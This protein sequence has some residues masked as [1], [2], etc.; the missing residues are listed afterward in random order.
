LAELFSEEIPEIWDTARRNWHWPQLP[1]PKAGKVGSNGEFPFQN[2][3][4]MLTRDELRHGSLYLESLFE[5]LIVHYIFCPRSM[6]TAGALALSAV[7]GLKDPALA[8]TM[9]NIFTDIVVDSFRLE[10]SCE[11]EEKVV[12]AWS[13]I[14]EQELGARDR[15]VLGFLSKYWGVSLLDCDLPEVDLLL[16]A[17]SPGVR[18]R[19]LWPRQC[20]Q[21]AR[22]LE[23]LG[24]GRLGKGPIR[25]VEI[26]NGSADSVPMTS[27]AS[28]IEPEVY[29]ST[30]LALGIKGDLKR[31]YRD[32]SCEIEIRSLGR[33][34]ESQYPAGTTRWRITDPPSEIDIPYSLSLSPRLIPGI[35][36]YKRE[37]EI[38]Q[39]AEM[40]DKVPDLLAVL[41]SSKSMEGHRLGT[42]THKAT[43][44]A[45]KACQFAHS[46]GAEVAAINFGDRFVCQGWTRD[47]GAVEDVLVEYHCTRTH[48]PGKA[49]SEL[50]REREGCLIL[51]ITDTH[52]Q[53]L[54]TEWESLRK[55][56]KAG[57]FVLICIDQERKDKQVDEALSS[58][59]STYYVDEVEDLVGLVV[60]VTE[61]AYSR[62]QENEIR[63]LQ[64]ARREP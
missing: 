21:T 60:D 38:C 27:L 10:R 7:R 19:S 44:A 14:A 59:G 12:L 52:I 32:Q 25:S 49:I 64:A 29:E 1:R 58:L 17:F 61:R 42:K 43:L 63:E 9:V 3:D 39:M 24:P 54:H 34:R 62:S 4:L 22:I 51:C 23:G 40:G 13:L 16:Q 56:S 33:K 37:N 57:T 41:D 26:L 18:N 45:F 11:D 30:L 28:G 35:T 15:A 8:K 31:W 47:L 48:I 20:Q 53:N 50:A 2:Y 46:Q 6:E 5:H 36:T 55:A